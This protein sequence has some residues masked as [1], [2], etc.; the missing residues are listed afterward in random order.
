MKCPWD[1]GGGE[2]EEEMVGVGCGCGE[3]HIT[4]VMCVYVGVSCPCH[5]GWV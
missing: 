5:G 3:D 4:G 1:C 2:E